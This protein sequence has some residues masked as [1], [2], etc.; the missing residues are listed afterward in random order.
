MA[1]HIRLQ[2]HGAKHRPFYHIVAA[3][4]RKARDGRFLEKLGYSVVLASDGSEAVEKYIE[5][6]GKLS[7]VVSDVTMPKMNGKQM[8]LEILNKNPKAVVILCSG[9]TD[10]GTH[11]DLVR[12]GAADFFQ[13]P[14]TISVLAKSLHECLSNREV[15][16]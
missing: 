12:A 10:E 9:F 11:D 3:D 16:I 14:Y 15:N 2:R 1:V 13:K 6:R 7:A 4:H 8:L 5:N